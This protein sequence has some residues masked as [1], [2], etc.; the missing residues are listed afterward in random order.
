[1]THIPEYYVGAPDPLDPSSAYGEGKRIAELLCALYH[2]QHGL[3]TKIARCFAFVGPYLPLDAHFA[4]GNF[5]HAALQGESIEVKGDGT[6]YRSYLYAADLALWLWTIIFRGATCRPYNVG[7]IE[8]C[9]IS[10]V[11]KL[12]ADTI[13]NVHVQTAHP[14]SERPPLRYVPDVGR[15]G[16]E[17]GL[18]ALINLSDGVKRTLDFHK[19]RC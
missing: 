11:A 6:P 19:G 5:I 13:G 15:A 14:S 9:P 4:V 8:S 3:E 2:R 1:M 7:A 18:R 17:L 16:T 12:V 10:E